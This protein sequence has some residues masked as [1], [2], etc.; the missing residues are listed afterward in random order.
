MVNLKVLEDEI[1]AWPNVRA[2]PHRFGGR[3]FCFGKAEIGHLH[4]NGIVDIPFPRS[5]HDLILKDGLAKEHH[6]VPDSGWITFM[7][8]SEKDFSHA[9]WLLRISYLRYALKAAS[10]P[11]D[12]FEKEAETLHLK[13][14]LIAA[15][16]RFVPHASL[17]DRRVAF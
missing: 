14:E 13:A 5:V 7:V 9:L 10:D 8:R 16:E 4:T 2:H 17:R 6:W 3:E 12:L 11:R 15:L 1:C